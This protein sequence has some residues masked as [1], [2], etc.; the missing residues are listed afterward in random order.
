MKNQVTV[1]S[2]DV[3]MASRVATAKSK[4]TM[5]VQ[6]AAAAVDSVR[7]TKALVFSF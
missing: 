7:L 2:A 4:R 5:E 1:T 6:V 3:L